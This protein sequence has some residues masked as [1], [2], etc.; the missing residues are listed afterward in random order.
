[1]HNNLISV[2]LIYLTSF[3][4]RYANLKKFF[5][6]LHL[7]EMDIIHSYGKSLCSVAE[8]SS[9]GD[10]VADKENVLWVVFVYINEN[11]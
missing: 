11:N 6:Q 1:M 10:N 4:G 5:R 7:I 3:F 2:H 9:H 8:T